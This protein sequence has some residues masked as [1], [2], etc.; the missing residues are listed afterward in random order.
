MSKIRVGEKTTPL[1]WAPS[2]PAARPAGAEF[3]PG[4]DGNPLFCCRFL[5]FWTKMGA[6][7]W[8]WGKKTTHHFRMEVGEKNHSPL[9][10]LSGFSP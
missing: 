9:F 5:Q 1:F 3:D 4:I 6:G 7:P 2:R 10:G 8:A